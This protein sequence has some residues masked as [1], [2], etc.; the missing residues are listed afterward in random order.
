[1]SLSYN[2]NYWHG[3]SLMKMKILTICLLVV[4][5]LVMVSL[6][7]SVEST[8]IQTVKITD[9]GVQLKQVDKNVLKEKLHSYDIRT[10]P[11]PTIKKAIEILHTDFHIVL[12]GFIVILL[13]Y[14]GFFL[15]QIAIGPFLYTLGAYTEFFAVMLIEIIHAL[16]MEIYWPYIPIKTTS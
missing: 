2:A 7:P 6:I 16:V 13:F 15:Q 9:I 10:N 12:P 8:T 1:M 14:L 4:A 5:A 11:L 3:G